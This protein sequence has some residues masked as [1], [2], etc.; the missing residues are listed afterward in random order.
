VRLSFSVASAMTASVVVLAVG[1]CGDSSGPASTEATEAE[2]STTTQAQG[3]P[4]GTADFFGA[5]IASTTAGKPGAVVQ[6]VQPDS[7][8]QLKTGDVIIACNGT[9]VTSSGDLIEAIGTPK[10]GEQF[11]L[12]VIRGSHGFTLTE[13]QSPTAY[14]GAG[15]KD[16]SGSVKGAEV[17][18]VAA[19]SPAAAAHLQPGDVITAADDAPVRSVSDLLQAIGPHASGDTISLAV[20]RGS[21]ELTVGAMLTT[22]P[23]P[24]AGR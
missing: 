2:S 1:G 11:T 7:K 6:S 10:V 22:R 19:N 17:V 12:R 24:D 16:A 18:T 23:A 21:R 9:R 15:V 4:P 8:S 5:T 14:L 20:S 13:V 3:S